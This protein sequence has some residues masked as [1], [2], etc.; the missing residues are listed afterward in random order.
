LNRK[1]TGQ[2]VGGVLIVIA[3]IL[4][5]VQHFQIYNFYG[6]ESNKWYFYGLVGL[7]GLIGIIVAA[8]STTR[9]E[10]AQPQPQPAKQGPS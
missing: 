4:G 2:I 6:D 8:W 9:R 1:V 10:E 3:I 5:V 7:I